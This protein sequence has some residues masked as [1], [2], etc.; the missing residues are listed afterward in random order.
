M[1]VKLVEYLKP[2][3]T[4]IGGLGFFVGLIILYNVASPVA[5][6]SRLEDRYWG[7][8]YNTKTFGK[9]WCLCKFLRSDSA[10]SMVMLSPGKT[11][12]VFAVRR[13]SNDPNFAHLYMDAKDSTIRIEAKQLYLGKRYAFERLMV[14][15]F[16][17]FW[18]RNDDDSIRGYF[19]SHQETAEF[20]VE[21]RLEGE[22]V[23][24]FCNQYVLGEHGFSSL[25]EIDSFLQ[26]AAARY[27]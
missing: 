10:L 17:D 19:V 2:G 20:A 23:L 22:R 1:G 12:D 15:R 9:V 7:G 16:R 18:K 8:Y 4:M 21:R 13:E 27:E 5:I 26:S 6:M 24:E 3:L 11:T 14:G 25:Q